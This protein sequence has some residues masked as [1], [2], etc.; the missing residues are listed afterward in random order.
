MADTILSA[1]NELVEKQGG[2]VTDNKL[3]FKRYKG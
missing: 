2:D 1:L 3:N